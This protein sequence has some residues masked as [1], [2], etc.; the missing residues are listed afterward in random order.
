MHKGETM[1]DNVRAELKRI[2]NFLNTAPGEDS[3]DL[4]HVITAL[5]GPDDDDYSVKTSTTSV[6]RYALGL[7]NSGVAIVN[8]DDELK[9]DDRRV[10]FPLTTGY[11]G[12]PMLSTWEHFS[13]HA[14]KAFKVLGLAWDKTNKPEVKL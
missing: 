11:N 3:K 9:Y 5:R 12:K 13:S 8:S 6:I 7:T 1:N 2:V 4:W 10:R 14:Y